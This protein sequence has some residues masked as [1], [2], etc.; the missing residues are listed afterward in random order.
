VRKLA[1]EHNLSL[2]RVDAILK[3]K[4]QEKQMMGEVR[5]KA[6]KF[7]FDCFGFVLIVLFTGC[8]I[9]NQIF[10]GNGKADWCSAL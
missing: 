9:A 5:V 8:P 10:E 4:A 2:A 6:V 3:L 7:S 1:T